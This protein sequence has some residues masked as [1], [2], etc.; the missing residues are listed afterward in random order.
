MTDS[1]TIAT[2]LI[3]LVLLLIILGVLAVLV[4]YV[5]GAYRRAAHLLTQWATTNG[6]HIVES[7]RR[8]M[9]KGPFTWTSSQSQIVYH[10]TVQDPSGN[11]R[12]GWVRCGNFLLGP[13]K[14]DVD[15]SWDD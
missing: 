5:T 11:V 7:D 15:V 6:Y 8:Y 13:W 12:R 1:A 2:L 3:S 4:A 9:R 14:D 10:V